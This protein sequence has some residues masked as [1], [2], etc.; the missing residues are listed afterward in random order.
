VTPHD[1]DMKSNGALM[2][3]MVRSAHEL[4][5]PAKAPC[6]ESPIMK[7]LLCLAAVLAWFSLHTAT[8]AAPTNALIV[9]LHDD[10]PGA[11]DGRR[12]AQQAVRVAPL[13]LAESLGGRWHRVQA[14]ADDRGGALRARLL[15]DPRVAAVLP[16]VREQRL[17]VTPNDPRFSSQ[18]WLKAVA[19]GNTGAAGFAAAWS[20]NTGAAG[21]VAVA[22]LDSGITSPPE[23]N[24]RLLPG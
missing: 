10:G 20:R 15:A 8:A 7:R 3:R 11:P 9:L 1:H 6:L 22:V 23:L 18:W 17:S 5:S 13:P 14:G 4:S 16:D 12:Q 19:A 21:P 24:P 2:S